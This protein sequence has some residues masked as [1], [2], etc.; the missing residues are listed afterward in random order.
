MTRPLDRSLPTKTLGGPVCRSIAHRSLH[1]SF[2]GTLKVGLAAWQ[3]TRPFTHVLPMVG[4]V[5]G[6][7]VALE[8]AGRTT[9]GIPSVS[10]PAPGF[11]GAVL[12]N[13][14]W[15]LVAVV[16]IN[17]FSNVLNQICDLRLDRINKPERPLPSGRISLPLARRLLVPLL[18]LAVASG[19]AVGSIFVMLVLAAAV[20]TVLYSTPPF[21]LK[22]WAWAAQ[23]SIALP[24]G[25]LPKV[26]G[27]LCVPA[28]PL[29]T[30]PW[31][32]GAVFFLF[33]LG[34]SATKDLSDV[35]GDRAEG[36]RTL[37]VLYGPRRAVRIIS[38]FL[39]L[40]WLN[41]PLG[42]LSLGGGP[43]FFS[44]DPQP[45]AALAILLAGYGLFI[46]RS[47]LASSDERWLAGNHPAW[48]HMYALA[49]LA[50][51]GLAVAYVL[52]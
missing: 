16:A 19:F 47:M 31:A 50:H 9:G 13:L 42:S 40:P 24:R 43:A 38:P 20:S 25:L 34:A 36:C 44:A 11:E 26:C 4:L 27:W 12:R 15:A 22:R 10:T 21:R 14:I 32:I 33:L 3:L 2:R 8:V 30:E 17:A 35:A 45:L 41:L 46:S 18:A 39:V 1:G 23:A 7:A 29:G 49:T 48:T 37:P 51:V 52:S 6:T 28:L 5:S